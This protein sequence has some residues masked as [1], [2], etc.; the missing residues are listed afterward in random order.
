[1]RKLITTITLTGILLA[2][3]GTVDK[4]TAI[5]QAKDVVNQAQSVAGTMADTAANVSRDELVRLVTEKWQAQYD[6]WKAEGATVIRPDGSIDWQGV[7]NLS[8]A[9]KSLISVGPYEFLAVLRAGGAI[10]IVRENKNTKER[11][12]VTRVK[13]VVEHGEVSIGQ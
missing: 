9:E 6:Q 3:C 11:S 13:L 1:M 5:N 4:Q 12:L 8:L 2:G 10:E 7:S